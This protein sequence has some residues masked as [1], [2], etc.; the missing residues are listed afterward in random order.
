MRCTSRRGR[1]SGSIPQAVPA[2]PPD[3][4]GD[5]AHPQPGGAGNAGAAWAGGRSGARARRA[6]PRHGRPGRQQPHATSGCAAATSPLC[7]TTWR[8]SRDLATTWQQGGIR[9]RASPRST[10]AWTPT[11]FSPRAMGACAARR[12]A[13]STRPA[14]GW[15]APSAA[16]RPSRTRP[17]WP[18][19]LCARWNWRPNAAATLRLVM[20]GDG[21]LRAEARHPADRRRG[22]SGLAARRAQRC[23]RCHAR[24]DCFVLPSLAEGIS[25]TILEAMASGLA[26]GGHRCG[27]Q[28]RTGGHGRTG[29]CR[30]TGRCRGMARRP[31]ADGQRPG[32][33]Q[34]HGAGRPASV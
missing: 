26:G 5:R 29:P 28:C 34:R 4:P 16:C 24:P 14:L 17:C 30:A 23:A 7:T 10:T 15:W 3:A 33:R 8:L 6:R 21:P 9:P 13:P 25:N 12:A 27:R 20:V 2:V 19:P 18:G 22:R 1:A 11:R 31:G 32:A